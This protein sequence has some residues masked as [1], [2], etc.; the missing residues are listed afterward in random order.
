ME[1]RL[2]GFVFLL[3]LFLVVVLSLNFVSPLKYIVTPAN[4]T[5]YSGVVA[6]NVS[7]INGTDFTDATNATVYYNLSG[8]WTR[9]ASTLDCNNAALIGSCNG[10]FNVSALGLREGIYGINATLSNTTTVDIGGNS[11][12]LTGVNV[13]THHVILDATPPNVSAFYTTLNRGNYTGT[14]TLNVSV[15]DGGMGVQYVYFNV[16]YPN[17]TQ[18]NFTQ[19]SASGIYYSVSLITT[20]FVD[21]YYNITAYANDTQLGNFNKTEFIYVTFDNT[22]PTGSVSCSPSAVNSGDTVTCSCSVSD[23]T[24]G[25]NSS[26]TTGITANPPTT[27]TGTFTSTC[28][29]MDMAGNSGSASTTYTVE[30]AASGAGAGVGVAEVKKIHSWTKITP[31]V[32]SIMKNFNPEI[33]VKEIEITVSNEAQ[34]VKITV[35]KYD[36][37]PAEVTVEKTGKVYRYLQVN[38]QN[39]GEKLEKAVMTLQVEKSWVSDNNLDKEN[40]ALL[41][42][43]ETAQE[44]NELTTTFTEE[45]DN[46][47]YY[48]AELTSFSYFAI[49]EKARVEEAPEEEEEVTPLEEVIKKNLILWIVIALVVLAVIVGVIV[50]KRKKQ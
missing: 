36:D 28:S 40:V 8:V 31:G 45:D 10:T 20:G 15:T 49:G 39:L 24:S 21:G 33:G 12:N 47:N 16:T 32:V 17:G 25:V 13:P 23:A 48:E 19:G 18:L 26:A 3:T 41:K 4:Y 11:F 5:N 43:D 22:V 27:N 6:F 2:R 37:K 14:I 29:F 30:L 1:K 46:Y 44:W 50:A 35:T 9:I 42:F 34:N 7:Y 38:A